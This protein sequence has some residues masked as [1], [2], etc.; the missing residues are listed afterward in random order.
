MLS[1]EKALI[2]FDENRAE[3]IDALKNRLTSDEVLLLLVE[4]LELCAIDSHEI[5]SCLLKS[6]LKEDLIEWINDMGQFSWKPQE[7]L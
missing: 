4:K 1:I 3:F 6:V 5:M 7:G 2:I